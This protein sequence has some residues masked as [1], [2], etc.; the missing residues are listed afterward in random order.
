MSTTIEPPASEPPASIEPPKY[1]PKGIDAKRSSQVQRIARRSI[2]D[3]VSALNRPFYDSVVVAGA[4]LTASIFAARLARS[5][6]FAGKV[7]LAGSPPAETRKL[8]DGASLRGCAVDFIS[9]AAGCTHEEYVRAALGPEWPKSRANRQ[10]G[11]TTNVNGRNEWTFTKTAPWQG[12]NRGSDRPLVYA[13]RNSRMIGAVRELMFREGIIETQEEITSLE[14]AR[15][16]APGARPLV[17]NTSVK[18]NLLANEPVK[19]TH[20]TLAYQV[21]LM[22]KPGGLKKPVV[23]GATFLAMHLH[24]DAW[25]VGFFN[26]FADPLSPRSSWYGI[27]VR[28]VT[29]G[30]DLDTKAELARMRQQTIDVADAIGLEP[31]DESETGASVAIPGSAWNPKLSSPGTFE[32]RAWAHPGVSALY[33][34]GI[35]SGAV[36]AVAAAEAILRGGNPELAIQRSNRKL[37]RALRVWHFECSSVAPAANALLANVPRLALAYPHGS[38]FKLWASAA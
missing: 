17:V 6:E 36:A 4:G 38:S 2:K 8:N 35:T 1:T 15:S 10:V 16:L 7:V 28:P 32:L 37:R 27:Y 33:A 29:Y 20:G 34:D 21:P 26:P 19:V 3:D 11:G 31:D 23:S 25:E 12:G 22:E 9:Y 13:G 30:S 24:D 5:P 18:G 14:H